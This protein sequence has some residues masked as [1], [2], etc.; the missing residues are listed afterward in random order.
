MNSSNLV[1]SGEL[2][3]FVVRRPTQGRVSAH[4]AYDIRDPYALSLTMITPGSRPVT[5]TFSRELLDGGL[6]GGFGSGAVVIAPS[7]DGHEVLIGLHAAPDFAV[8]HLD[9]APIRRFL[10][11]TYR[12]VQPGREHEHVNIDEVVAQMLAT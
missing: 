6:L 7:P 4:F 5:W 10:A 12:A 8:I 3:G 1:T 11:K 9:P 2:R